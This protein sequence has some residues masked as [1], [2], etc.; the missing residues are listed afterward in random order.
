MKG[1][2]SYKPNPGQQRLNKI[3][4]DDNITRVL[5]TS[6]ARSGKTFEYVRT[7]FS[8]AI[9]APGSR[10]AMIRKYFGEAKKFIWLDTMPKVLKL[11]YPDLLG[12]IKED[13]SNYFY[14]FPEGSEIWIGGLD[15]K[16]RADKILGGE[17]NT[18]YFNECSEIAWSSVVTALTRLAMKIPKKD[19]SQLINKAFF[20]ENP[21]LKSHWSYKLFIEKKDPITNDG[22]KNKDKH[23]HIKLHPEDNIEN[24]PDGY[25]EDTLRNLTG[26]ARLRFYE[27]KF[28]D[29]VVGA[30]W[31]EI[32][33]NKHRVTEY[34]RL[35]RII[36]AVDPA[37]TANTDSN[38]TGII[39]AGLGFNEQYYVLGDMSG[40]Y[41]PNE[42]GGRAVLAF[43]KW[44]ADKI[45]GEVNQ[46]GDMVKAII[47]NIRGAISFGSV[48]ATRGKITRAEPISSL[49]DDGLIHH[50]GTFPDL[51]YQM[52]TYTGKEA[53]PDRMDALVWGLTE[54]STNKTSQPK[55]RTV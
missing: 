28:Q 48:R 39:I 8:R 43:D 17:Y 19:G 37:I 21:P 50:V 1:T 20:D 25:I 5:A 18:L 16:E 40:I 30:L 53:S 46:G 22:I 29:E 3:L 14:K 7:I 4:R 23:A 45:I 31:N 10:H 35:R 49:Y 15:D 2:V 44:K 12:H 34:P 41:T 51:E 33:I 54:L 9:H 6:G 26:N 24:L 36:V 47:K 13:N 11:C 27:G 55:W 32:I 38:E 42:W 52:C